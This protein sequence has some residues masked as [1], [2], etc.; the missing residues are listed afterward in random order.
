MGDLDFGNG[1]EMDPS[2]RGGNGKVDPDPVSFRLY[3]GGSQSMTFGGEVKEGEA[4]GN[5]TR[6]IGGVERPVSPVPQQGP[7][8][9]RA[10]W[11][12][13]SITIDYV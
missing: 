7:R 8:T 12:E 2:L 5:F 6:P 3:E 9:K 1:G 13:G 11:A 10:P 4:E